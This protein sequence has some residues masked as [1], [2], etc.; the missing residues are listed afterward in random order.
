MQLGIGRIRTA[1]AGASKY[2]TAEFLALLVADFAGKDPGYENGPDEAQPSKG[3]ARTMADE[4]R[5]ALVA[6]GIYTTAHAQPTTAQRDSK[7]RPAG[8]HTWTLEVVSQADF[9]A[10]AA[11]RKAN[12]DA[13]LA[14]LAAAEAEAD[15]A[16][17]ADDALAEA[18]DDDGG[19]DED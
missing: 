19:P 6:E 3:V 15:D 11:Q 14:A 10:A 12:A 18:L 2:V 9:E 8:P 7:N 4:Y 13:K 17:E 5:K 16:T 1:V